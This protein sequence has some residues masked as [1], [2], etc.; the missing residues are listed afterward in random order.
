MN[1][2]GPSLGE[3]RRFGNQVVEDWLVRPTNQEA[4]IAKRL[5]L[6][7]NMP[8]GEKWAVD[9]VWHLVCIHDSVVGFPLFIQYP[10]LKWVSNHSNDGDTPI[11]IEVEFEI[12]GDRSGRLACCFSGDVVGVITQALTTLSTFHNG[13]QE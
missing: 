8:D 4:D 11:A 13:E 5:C 1:I 7:W 10:T 12:P 2:T 3:L 6:L 9:P